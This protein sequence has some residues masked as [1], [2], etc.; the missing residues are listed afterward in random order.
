MELLFGKD[1]INKYPN[2]IPIIVTSRNIKISKSRFV[3]SDEICLGAFISYLRTNH[4][5]ISQEQGIV[6]FINSVIPKINTNM[7]ELYAEYHD[8][9]DYCLHLTIMTES[10]FG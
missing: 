9:K 5:K 10:I 3:V 8:K 7:A 4:L 2:R 6:V 1:I